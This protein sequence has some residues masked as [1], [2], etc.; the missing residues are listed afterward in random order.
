MQKIIEG[1][2]YLYKEDDEWTMISGNYFKHMA[3]KS[4]RNVTSDTTL[5][6]KLHSVQLLKLIIA[7]VNY[8]PTLPPW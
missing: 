8:L 1:I 5:T 2:H 4:T 3:L 6:D 7:N